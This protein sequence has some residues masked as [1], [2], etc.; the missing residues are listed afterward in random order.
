MTFVAAGPYVN[1]KLAP[2]E[3]VKEVIK[4][5]SEQKTG[6]GIVETHKGQ[7]FL[8]EYAQLNTHKEAHVGHSQNTLLLKQL[9]T[10]HTSAGASH[11][12]IK[13]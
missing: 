9:A 3:V 1:V 4:A 6:Y 12:M 7:T 10:L 5:V 2:D 11:Q 13:S 8:L